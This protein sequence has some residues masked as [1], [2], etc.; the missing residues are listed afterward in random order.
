MLAIKLAYR[1]LMGAGLRTWLNVFVLSLSYVLIIY[2]NGLMSGWN[3][4]AQ[5]D[6]IAWE[7]ADGM[8]WYKNYDPYD[9]FT[10]SESHAEIAGKF[11]QGAASKKLVPILISEATIYPEG[12]IQSVMLKGIPPEQ[13]VLALPTSQMNTDAEEIPAII[14]KRMAKNNHLKNGDVL[15]VRWRDANGMFDAQDV[16]IVGIF[17][18][19]VPNID[20]S[21][22]WVPLSKL[23]EMKQLPNQ[24]TLI[25]KSPAFDAEAVEENWEYKTPGF[26]MQDIT[27]M[28][29]TKR[30]GS[31]FFYIIILALALLAIFD[32]QVLSIFRRQKEIGTYVAIGMTRSQVVALF[33][34]EGAFHA[35]LAAI[36]GAVYGIPLLAYSAVK[37]FALP[38]GA[39]DMG[40]AMTDTLYP[41][42]GILL[43]LST[44]LIVFLVTTIVS[45]LP[46][47][48]ISKMEP[49]DAIKGKI[50]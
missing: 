20:N 46:A 24:A 44:I 39:D 15:L 35:V 27:E 14:G 18:C 50:Q 32:T 38:E 2:F 8:F 19:N 9:P 10:L 42:Y 25:V 47:R 4:Q 17:D 12:R 23:Q 6:M 7:V 48:K 13:E 21:Q 16:R 30:I 43:I 11:E 33:T 5:T 41:Y 26:L 40:L 49:T 22:I 3:R 1:N 31:S 37:G 28:V 36:V 45:Y 29:K 34:V